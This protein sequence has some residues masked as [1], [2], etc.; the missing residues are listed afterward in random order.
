MMPPSVTISDEFGFVEARLGPGSRVIVDHD[1]EGKAIFKERMDA[2]ERSLP[3]GARVLRPGLIRDI[4]HGQRCS[5]VSSAASSAALRPPAPLL[6]RRAG[7]PRDRESEDSGAGPKQGQGR[8]KAFV[9]LA[10]S[11]TSSGNQS[12]SRPGSTLAV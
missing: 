9:F 8:E 5:A 2:G 6:P 4:E 3:A 7:R 11:G 1:A 12:V 10:S